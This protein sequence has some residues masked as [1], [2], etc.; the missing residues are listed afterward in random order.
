ML[1]LFEYCEYT[2]GDITVHFYTLNTSLCLVLMICRYFPPVC[3][4]SLV[5]LVSDAQQ[6]DSYIYIYICFFRF[7][8]I[9]GHYKV[10][11]TVSCAL[12]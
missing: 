12:W 6:S 2:A 4:L 11:S 7:F 1:P 8:S 9:V 10:L 5:V 3:G